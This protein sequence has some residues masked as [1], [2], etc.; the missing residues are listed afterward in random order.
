MINNIK[1]LVIVLVLGAGIWVFKDWQYQRS[2]NKIEAQ[3]KEWLKKFDSLQYAYVVLGDKQLKE[4]VEDRKDLKAIIKD[5]GVKIERIQRVMI[6]ALSYRDTVV[7]NVD[8]SPVL[9]AINTRKDFTLPIIDSTKCLVIKG[10]VKYINEK[11]SF[12]FDQR[13]YNDNTTVVAYWQRRQ[14]KLLWFKTRLFGKKEGT[15]I[16]SSEC[17]TSKTIEIEKKND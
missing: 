13:D 8:L 7:N 5:N 10:T 2:E 16:V 3:N 11:L 9:S 12:Q 17:G 6:Q 1:F 4:Y 14:W 15:A